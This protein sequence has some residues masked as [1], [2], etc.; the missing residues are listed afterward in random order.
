MAF[1][2]PPG[3]NYTE[4]ETKIF[5]AADIVELAANSLL[6]CPISTI[7]FILIL[8]TSILH[9]NL[10]LILLCQSLCI[11][12]RGI[13]RIILNIGRL[14]LNDYV[15]LGPQSLIIMYMLP[16]LIRNC[17]MHVI[18]IERI[19]ATI[20]SKNYEKQ[21]NILFNIIWITITVIISCF[22]SYMISKFSFAQ[23]ANVSTFFVSL[24]LGLAEIC[25]LFWIL[26][27]NKRNYD[28]KFQ[29]GH[30]S[31]SERYQV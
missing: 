21:R 3:P 31:L 19:I 28:K 10:K 9:P 13:G 6:A 1:T 12:I 16:I 15:T 30:Q 7:N 26:R 20:K 17:I 2:F 11:F 4:T 14:Y 23:L 18:V 24:I 29:E 5:L 25:A 8:K 22:N 27:Q